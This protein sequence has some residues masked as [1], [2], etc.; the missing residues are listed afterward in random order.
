MKITDAT[1][2]KKPN[3]RGHAYANHQM[4]IS[5]LCTYDLKRTLIRNVENLNMLKKKVETNNYFYGRFRIPKFSYEIKGLQLHINM[6]FMFGKQLNRS[7]MMGRKTFSAFRDMVYEDMVNINDPM[8]FI[9]FNLDNFIIRG[10]KPLGEGDQP[11]EIAYVDLE[12]YTG[13]CADAPTKTFRVN[14]FIN[15][16]QWMEK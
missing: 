4:M 1:T 15:N 7:G 8:A 9:D 10:S 5:K 14:K 12:A 2:H 11:W 6:E 3:V 16:K 13:P